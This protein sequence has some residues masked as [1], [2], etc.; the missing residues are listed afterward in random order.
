M[1]R[2]DGGTSIGR[3]QTMLYNADDERSEENGGI[4]IVKLRNLLDQ[5]EIEFFYAKCS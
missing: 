3:E 5:M 4:T 2:G 1:F